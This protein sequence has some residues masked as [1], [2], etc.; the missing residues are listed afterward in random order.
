MKPTL[1]GLA[2]VL[3]ACLPVPGPTAGRTGVIQIEVVAGPVCPVEREPPDPDCDPRP[4]EGARVF[5]QPADGRDILVG[6]AMTDAEGNAT[7]R[8]QPGDY[9][10]VGSDV[11]GLMGQPDPMAVTV[12]AAETV[13]VTLSYDTGIR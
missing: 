12:A 2:I 10:V 9:L 1:I 5:L 11:E 8:V 7:I 6:E 3:S 13:T 4:V